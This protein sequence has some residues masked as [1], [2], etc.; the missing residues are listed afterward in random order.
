MIK[1]CYRFLIILTALILSCTYLESVN[2]SQTIKQTSKVTIQYAKTS[3]PIEIIEAIVAGEDMEGIYTFLKPS[4]ESVWLMVKPGNNRYFML[5]GY[6][7]AKI[8]YFASCT[9]RVPASDTALNVTFGPY[10]GPVP[11]KPENLILTLNGKTAVNATWDSAAYAKMYRIYRSEQENS[12]GTVIGTSVKTEYSDDKCV[13]GKTYYYRISAYNTTGESV[14][15]DQ[16][17][18][19]LPPPDTKPT[20]PQNLA[21]RQTGTDFITIGWDK[22][23]LAAKYL[24]YRCEGTGDP[25]LFI[26]STTELTYTDTNV[27]PNTTYSYAVSA[28]NVVGES[29]KSSK[30][31]GTTQGGVP[32]VPQNL[33]VKTTSATS[34]TI[35]WDKS[36]QATLYRI[37][38]A[39]GTQDPVTQIDSTADQTYTNTNLKTNSEYSYAVSAVN[40]AGASNKSAKVTGKTSV[41]VPSIPQNVKAVALS[42]KSI[43]VSWQQAENADSYL[44]YRSSSATGQYVEDGSSQSTSYVSSNLQPKTT[45]YYKVKAVNTAGQSD[46]SA[47]ANATTNDIPVTKP[48]KPTGVSAQALTATS[49]LVKWQRSVNASLYII[50]KASSATGPFIVADSTADTFYTNTG[51][52]QNTTYYYAVS[53]KNSAGESDK[54]DVVSAQT[55]VDLTPPAGLSAKAASVS[56]IDLSWNSVTGAQLYRIYRSLSQGGTFTQIDSTQ[57]TSYA[58]TAL[59]ANTTYYYKLTAKAGQSVSGFSAVVSA[60]TLQDVPAVPTGLK[61]TALSSTQIKVE[62]AAVSGATG[63]KFYFCLTATGTFNLAGQ[64]A[65][66]SYTHSQL[67]ADTRYYYKLSAINQ[68]GESKQS[69]TVSAKTQAGQVPTTPTGLKALALTSSQIKISFTAVTGAT[70]YGI[71]HCTT[72]TGTFT[73]LQKIT[74]V[75]D[76]HTNLAPKSVHYYQVS[77]FNQ[78]GESPLSAAVS[79]T[80]PGKKVAFINNCAG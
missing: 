39:D 75:A 26:D 58:D 80:T 76:T 28:A 19:T 42:E 7:N 12:T 50:Y 41:T 51:L 47:A 54:S 61:A 9:T 25:N 38:R 79:A 33:A 15:S 23:E 13:P 40:S 70:Q 73:L 43:S 52:T 22:S 53:A 77:A 30:V 32:D 55:P 8:L 46:F 27:K 14:L 44:I 65:T 68:A 24:V 20:T 49:I 10:Q 29:N 72:S 4:L 48:S 62:C 37:Y 5:F 21:V 2:N 45:Y 31:T 3:Q 57:N 67:T 60:T 74:A 18:I 56:R 6:V 71:Y 11:D 34:I 64:S 66:N 35:G 1:Y 36:L 59:T 16:Q 17:S 63:Y 78:N 69:D